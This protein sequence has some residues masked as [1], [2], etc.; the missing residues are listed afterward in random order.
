[1]AVN[2]LCED[3]LNETDSRS[4]GRYISRL[5]E[6]LKTGRYSY[7][8]S[9]PGFC[10]F[11]RENV[12]KDCRKRFKLH[13]YPKFDIIAVTTLFTFCWKE[14]IDT[15][16]G[17]K[18]FLAPSGRLLVGGVAA[19][20]V[21]EE[22]FRE[23]GI[24]P[25]AGLLNRPGMIDPG[26]PDII[27]TLPLD[28]SILEETEY[29]YPASDA[30]FA[31]TTRGCI[32]HCKFCAV[33]I[34]E[35]DYKSF[36]GIFEQI[37]Y[38][39]EHFGQKKDLLLMD[40]NVL[41]SDRLRD[42]IDEI[43]RCGFAKG[44]SYIPPDEYAVAIRNLKSGINT[45][46]YIRKIIALYDKSAS[47]MTE[48]ESG[49]FYIYREEH[50]LLAPESASLDDILE[51]DEY[52]S[53]IRAKYFRPVKRSRYADFN[54]GIDA[55]LITDG[56]MKMLAEI[57]IHPLR[58]AFD[59]IEEKDIYINAVRMAAKYGID[60]LSNYLLYNFED[61]PEDLYERMRINVELCEELNVKIY[62]FPMKYHPVK[63]PAYFRNRDYIGRHWNRKFIRAVQA[64]LKA[65]KGKIGRGREFFFEAFGHNTD[66]FHDI[67]YMPE[68]F[69]IYRMKYKHTLTAEWRRKFYA[70]ND[71][72][73][74]TAKA[75]IEAN[76]FTHEDEHKA[77]GRDIWE[78]LSYYYMER[79]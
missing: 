45:W 68:P 24:I 9:I 26:N 16:N 10:N 69:I 66:E 2:L 27:D 40:N 7:L 64:V 29:Q 43:K 75:V 18:E 34:L 21:P 67:L 55:R 73:M 48:R 25:V 63:D 57:N 65:T 14:T 54:Q 72:D 15:I 70:L 76:D 79:E 3:F 30:Y 17:A 32:R 60:D 61:K 22:I 20:L 1:M 58:I 77:L 38:I 6:Y 4:F 41:A 8:E 36:T 59:H 28:Y 56:S 53:K 46:A 47:R 35:P 50:N 62:S 78:V 12:I 44:A 33:P 13:D 51:A 39:D 49:E 42:I 19:S 71:E 37:Q 31:Y 23:T 74:Q 11:I 5:A 52:F